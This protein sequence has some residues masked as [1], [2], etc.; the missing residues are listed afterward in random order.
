M[1]DPFV[2]TG[3]TLRAAQ[4]LGRRSFGLDLHPM[5]EARTS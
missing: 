5:C 3:T 1:F 2:G 4:A